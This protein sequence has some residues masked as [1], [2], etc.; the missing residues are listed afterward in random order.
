MVTR[1][2]LSSQSILSSFSAKTMGG[3]STQ[4]SEQSFMAVLQGKQVTQSDKTSMVTTERVNNETSNDLRSTTDETAKM[5]E[6]VTTQENASNDKTDDVNANQSTEKTSSQSQETTKASKDDSEALK[7]LKEKLEEAGLSEDEISLI[8]A[9]MGPN[10]QE[11]VQNM[12][13]E[14]LQSLDVSDLVTAIQLLD[15]MEVN[16]ELNLEPDQ[17]LVQNLTD[18]LNRFET[19]LEN[20]IKSSG[21]DTQ[22]LEDLLTSMKGHVEEVVSE[23]ATETEVPVKAIVESMQNGQDK[24]SLKVED[25]SKQTEQT[26]L[27]S[28]GEEVKVVSTASSSQTDTDADTDTQGEFEEILVSET[29]KSDEKASAKSDDT[30][31]VIGDAE[32]DEV[33][34]NTNQTQEQRIMET[35]LKTSEVRQVPR[36]EIFSQVMDAIKAN[37][38]VTETGSSMMIKLN[39]EHLGDVEVKVTVNKGVVLAEIKVENEMV[40]AA[41]E[42]NLDQLKQSLTQKG[43]NSNSISVSVES[44]KKEDEQRQFANQSQTNNKKITVESEDENFLDKIASRYDHDGYYD[45]STI[46]YFG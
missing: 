27:E 22:K 11:I 21:G 15:N 40:K 36:Q 26:H 38:S 44:G 25:T 23:I 39:P 28:Q 17:T 2:L 30:S 41:I 19:E 1:E 37:L 3:T 33:T 29:P 4:S 24:A 13:L 32:V 16:Q 9:M 12:D 5:A 42:T 45:T 18:A 14:T 46:D 7:A 31:E 43:Y 35:L 34:L 10:L 8:M 20:A 6:N